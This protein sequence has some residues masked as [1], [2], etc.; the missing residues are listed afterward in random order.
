MRAAGTLGALIAA[1]V[2]ASA[3]ATTEPGWEGHGAEPFDAARAAC[4]AETATV[5]SDRQAAFEA[6]MNA[7]GWSRPD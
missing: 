2:L 6:C 1:A 3:C 7:R 4:E 5:A